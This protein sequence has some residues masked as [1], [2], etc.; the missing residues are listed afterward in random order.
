MVD[1]H[2]RFKEYSDDKCWQAHVAEANLKEDLSTVGLTPSQASK[3]RTT[4]FHFQYAD[5]HSEEIK[6]FIE[7]HEWLGNLPNRPTHRFIARHR[8]TGL[9]AGAVVMAIPNAFSNLLGK[10]NKSRE[11]LISRGACISWAPKNLGSW[12]IMRSIK[13]MVAN[14]D[15]RYFTAY[16]DPEAKELGTIYQACN[17]TYLGQTSGTDKQY[18]DEGYFGGKVKGW[19]SGREFRKK[20]NFMKYAKLIEPEFYK[21]IG[22]HDY[23]TKMFGFVSWEKA[24]LRPSCGKCKVSRW[25]SFERVFCENP[26]HKRQRRHTALRWKPN[27]KLV[28][29]MY[30]G[31][32]ER[33]KAE[34]KKYRDG[35]LV[36]SVP[37]KHKYCYILGSSKKETKILKNIFAE[38][39]PDKVNLPYPRVRGR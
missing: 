12:L 5:E 20:S 4:D 36:R 33:L 1:V 8:D 2:E 24:K 35:C 37:A 34:E 29:N 14:T 13:W 3:L 30:P 9:L 15:F 10:E 18:Y 38:R 17:F 16:S 22:F 11:K 7:R 39:N 25:K 28:E 19:F 21:E 32:K 6:G 31:L 26:E 23:E 27:W